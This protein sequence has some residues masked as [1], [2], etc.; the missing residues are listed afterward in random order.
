MR[1]ETALAA[2]S[3]AAGRLDR[4]LAEAFALS[5]SRL[6]PL[7]EEGRVALDGAVVRDPARRVAAG[8]QLRLALPPTQD[9]LPAAEDRALSVT[10]ED[11]DLIVI[12]KPPGLVVHP[13]PGHE[14][15]TLVNAL[16]GHCGTSLSGVGGVRRPGI[17]HRLDRDTS[18]LIVV[19]K[20]DHAHQGLA[21]QFAAHGRD[22][23]LARAYLALVWGAPEPR[24]GTVDARL[25]RSVRNREK[26]AV[27][28][29]GQGRHAVT[30]FRTLERFGAEAGVTLL[31]CTLET[32][33]THQIRVHLAHRGHPL[34][35]DIAYGAGFRTK[36]ARLQRDARAALECLGRQAL[37]ATL[38]G[39][40][41]P[42]T[43]E[44]LR[45]ESPA[46]PDLAALLKALRAEP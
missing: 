38:L 21:A 14:S 42:R 40:R 22:G 24:A 41:H 23:A 13:A 29:D 3:L 5:R 15:G 45:F 44:S 34:L 27:V 18:G 6:K 43:G 26:I 37:H 28:A 9:P 11:D 4:V 35:G 36:A 16:I 31:H 10:Y 2:T 19:A 33:R 7:I 32:G 30:H 17:V 20:N 1:E 12:D 25:A 8:A 46:P 39:F